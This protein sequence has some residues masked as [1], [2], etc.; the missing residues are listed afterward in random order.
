VL[1]P[2]L[3][4]KA[5]APCNVFVSIFPDYLIIKSH[6]SGPPLCWPVGLSCLHL[7]FS[8]ERCSD[9]RLYC[10]LSIHSPI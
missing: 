1:N 4:T 10:L 9:V 8:G 6:T 7:S 3:P 2:C 5:M